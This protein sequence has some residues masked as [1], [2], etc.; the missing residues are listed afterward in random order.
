MATHYDVI[1]VGGGL[2]GLSAAAF[3]ARAGLH[4][5]L[6][7]RHVQPGGYATTFIRKGYEFEVSL[8]ELSGIGPPLDRGPLWH[9]LDELGVTQRVDFLPI[10]NLYRTIA[11][12]VDVC[13]PTG[14]R[15][16]LDA[17]QCAFPHER[18]GLAR[19][20]DSV[21]AVHGD[22][23]HLQDRPDVSPAV[24]VARYPRAARAAALTLGDVLHRELRDPLAKLAL[25]QLWG[26]YG[27]PPSRLS[28]V[29]F[30]AATASY[31]RYGASYPKGKSQALSNAFAAV[32]GDAGGR[33]SLGNGVRRILVEGGRVT[34]VIDD[35]EEHHTADHIVCNASP[36]SACLDL[37]GRESI[38]ER[39]LRRLAASRPGLSSL[40]T[41]T[42]IEGAPSDVGITD[43]E[44]FLNTSVDLEE[45]YRGCL[46]LAPPVA[47]SVTTYDAVDPDFS[48]PGTTSVALTALTDGAAWRRLNPADY[49]ETKRHLAEA[50]VAQVEHHFP[51]FR[52]RIDV[53][54][55]GTPITNMRYT[56]NPYGAIYG[57]EMTPADNPAWRPGQEGP[58]DGL[59]FAG[60][61]TRPG[62]GYEP[63][64]G[65][66]RSAAEKVLRAMGTRKAAGRG[67]CAR[68]KIPRR[69]LWRRVE[70]YAALLGDAPALA[71]AL[72]KDALRTEFADEPLPAKGLVQRTVD[73]FHPWRMAVRIVAVEDHTATSKILRLT[74]VEGTFPPFE[75]GQYVTVHREIDGVQTSRAFSI[76]SPPG[77]LSTIELSVRRMPDGSFVEWMLDHL[78]PGDVLS[79]SG[80]DGDFVHDPI[81]D[82]NELVL[83]AGGSGIAPFRAMVEDVLDRGRPI[84]LT[85]IYGTRTADDVIFRAGLEALAMAHPERF[86]MALVVSDPE[87]AWAGQTGLIDTDCI[88]RNVPAAA[89]PRKTFFL[90][91]PAEMC[92]LAERSLVE[93]G[94][95]RRRM[96]F[97]AYGPP[98]EVTAEPDWPADVAADAVFRVTVQGQGAG[99][100]APAGEPLLNTLERAGLRIPSRCQT[101]V[102]GTC[103][104]RLVEGRVYVP[105]TVVL[106]QA[107][108]LARVIHPCVAYPLSDVVVHLP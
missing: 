73:R 95:P 64:I 6:F 13:V 78:K 60:A 57:Y 65:S 19:I 22:T 87:G 107:D 61:W 66:G 103:R 30:A 90:C 102:C 26:Y 31:L 49:P 69:P 100:A 46:E 8:H 89:L 44:I 40:T 76:A 99:F 58:V 29:Y 88:L 14:R 54:V 106:R 82:T 11:P 74:P 18:R 98:R 91:G 4:V 104:T 5:R 71:R 84:D 35:R 33:V 17:L 108:R 47:L 63:C 93:L 53:T 16:A 9:T 72:R 83:I 43:H 56:E 70:D 55:V 79:I 77:R 27:L 38:P 51:G 62:G 39:T 97:E 94:V 25:G 32:I 86:R 85:L 96:R 50:M 7:E 67:G 28:Y 20:I 52:D 10:T 45:Q 81:T 48:P 24:A 42:V 75:A 2:G 12:G 101:G 34:G 37:I 1:V 80:P 41:W 105:R 36:L 3:L 59:W 15:A 68:T 21:F 92:A 23:L